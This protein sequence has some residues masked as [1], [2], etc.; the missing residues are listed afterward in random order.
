MKGKRNLLL[1][2][3][4]LPSDC[5][6]AH[7]AGTDFCEIFQKETCNLYALALLLTADH[8]LAEECFVVGLDDCLNSTVFK[9]W[10]VSWSKRAVI[11]NA[12]R[13]LAPSV[14]TDVLA[15]REF[16]EMQVRSPFAQ[17]IFALGDFQR[18]V[19]VMSVLEGYRDLE[20][21]L[22]LNCSPKDVANARC[23]AL[24]ELAVAVG[25]NPPATALEHGSTSLTFPVGA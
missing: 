10:A 5:K 14:K 20:S 11:R 23:E 2:S 19:F 12:I 9:D 13:L 4:S 6:S 17:A 3:N 15:S 1:R 25:P 22:L 24:Q 21:S 8:T 7:A 18:F 16:D